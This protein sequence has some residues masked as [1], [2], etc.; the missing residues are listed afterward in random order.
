MKT[1]VNTVSIV[2]T[3]P[4]SHYYKKFSDLVKSQ[5]DGYD[6]SITRNI[7]RKKSKAFTPEE[8]KAI[9]DIRSFAWK[10]G[11]IH[12][13]RIPS[14]VVQ[15]TVLVY[16]LSKKYPGRVIA[17]AL[18]YNISN[19]SH[20]LKRYENLKHYKDYQETTELLSQRLTQC[21]LVDCSQEPL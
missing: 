16:L 5:V 15:K 1:K 11:L 10:L 13:V 12:K 4:E 18:E 2:I 3:I 17:R 6:C 8:F 21:S 19:V 14:V 20:S 9:A 7:V